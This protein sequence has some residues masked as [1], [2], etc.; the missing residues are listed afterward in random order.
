[1]T[2][3]QKRWNN[4][5]KYAAVTKPLKTVGFGDLWKQKTLEWY[6]FDTKSKKKQVWKGVVEL[7]EFYERYLLTEGQ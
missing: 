5:N 2:D 1:M 3:V 6:Y 4:G 7:S